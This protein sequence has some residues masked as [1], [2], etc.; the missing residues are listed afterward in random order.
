VLERIDARTLEVHVSRE[1]S[2]N[3]L[4]AALSGGGIEVM[5]LRNKQ[6]RLEKLFLDMVDQGRGKAA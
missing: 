1:Q 3:A 5:S 2:I 4:F 6:N